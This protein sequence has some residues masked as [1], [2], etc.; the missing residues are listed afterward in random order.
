MK[1]TTVMDVIKEFLQENKHIL[2]GNEKY[3]ENIITPLQ[4]SYDKIETF[5]VTYE[6]N[7]DK[8]TH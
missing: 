1:L 3:V 6:E 7:P 5:L 8:L 4:G 2:H